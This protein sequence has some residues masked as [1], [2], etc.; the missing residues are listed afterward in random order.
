MSE[1]LPAVLRRLLAEEYLGLRLRLARRFGSVEFAS[2]VLHD[3]WVRLDRIGEGTSGAAVHNPIAYLYRI[4]LNIAADRKRGDQR[5]LGPAEIALLCWQA[6]R[7]LDPAR[8][9]EARSELKAL[10]VAL[11]ELPERRRA[12][13]IA[14]RLEELPHKV[15]AERLGVTV[16]IVDREVKAA[17]AYFSTVVNK[18]QVP[19]RG[20]RP[21]KPS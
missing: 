11:E 12:I 18:K 5:R 2:E 9:A 7:E 8:I 20:P 6:E 17:L 14:A 3:A 4:A 1:T 21:L 19:R 10:A 15:V 16:R 13:F